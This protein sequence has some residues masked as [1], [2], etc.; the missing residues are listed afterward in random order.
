MTRKKQPADVASVF[1]RSRKD[2]KYTK[3]LEAMASGT[4]TLRDFVSDPNLFD[5]KVLNPSPAMWAI[6]DAAHGV[7]VTTID[8]DT[9]KGMFGCPLDQLPRKHQR[10]V[11]VH[12]G[13]RGGKTSRLLAVVA[14]HCGLTVPLPNV[15]RAEWARVLVMSKT[16][17]LA[18]QVLDAARSWIAGSELLTSMLTDEPATS[19]DG[20]V[21]ESTI[22][23]TE[24]IKLRRKHDGVFVE[25]VVK[26][27]AKGGTSAR[28]RNYPAVLMDE[29]AFFN[30]DGSSEINDKEL[31]RA[32]IQRVVPGGQLWMVSTA[33]VRDCGL[34]EE[35]LRHNYGV[36]EQGLAVV[37]GTRLLN[38]SWDPDHLIEDGMRAEDPENADREIE[39]VPLAAGSGNVITQE[40]LDMACA[41]TVDTNEIQ[42]TGAGADYAHSSDR[43]ALAIVQ[44]YAGGIFA[45]VFVKEQP[46]GPS[47]K[48]TELYTEFALKAKSM[49]AFTI[50]SDVTCKENIR[51]VYGRHNVSYRLSLL[52][53]DAFLAARTLFQE[54]R[55]SFAKLSEAD[56]KLL[57]KQLSKAMLIPLPGGKWRVKLESTKTVDLINGKGTTHQDLAVAFVNALVEV[58]ADRPE[59]W[60]NDIQNREARMLRQQRAS[61]YVP[62]AG[63]AMEL[64]NRRHGGSY[65]PGRFW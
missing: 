5:M 1:G 65:R 52:T 37:A 30:E 61:N 38:P 19:D 46:S 47:I 49:G 2:A 40:Q 39:C 57:C 25:I 58:G 51:E 35:K 18:K 55:V 33:W 32:A 14:L 28:G 34:L 42:A 56:K 54:G 64:R 20:E 9:A 31:H 29:A 44:R 23:N 4:M 7:P 62:P 27:A 6:Y 17:D 53:A 24:S 21:D 10:E 63:S 26:A 59:I 16:K 36:H 8:D 3:T 22:G 50:A 60:A 15:G 13:G 43:S 12:A 41:N 48:P 11:F 45:P